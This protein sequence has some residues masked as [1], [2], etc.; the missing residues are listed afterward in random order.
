MP[1]PAFRVQAGPSSPLRL[2]QT[3]R[4]NV[5]PKREQFDIRIADGY[6]DLGGEM[7]FQE[8]GE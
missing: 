6:T 8:N 5:D 3:L 1:L 2:F 7:T 4:R